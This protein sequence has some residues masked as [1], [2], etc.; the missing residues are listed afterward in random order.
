MIAE[1]DQ[2]SM[3]FAWML[4]FLPYGPE[5]KERRRLFQQYFASKAANTTRKVEETHYT[6][7]LLLRLLET[8]E[9]YVDHI[10]QSVDQC[11]Q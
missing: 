1:N 8:P 10:S 6:R 9:N 3:G 7:R 11:Y 4:V 5:W 2:Y